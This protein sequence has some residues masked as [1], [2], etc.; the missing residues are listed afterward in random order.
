M[1][2]NNNAFS[3]GPMLEKEKLAANGGKYANW[4]TGSAIWVLSSKLVKRTMFS[5][6]LF[7]KLPQ[8]MRRRTIRTFMQLKWM[9]TP[10][11]SA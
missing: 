4:R 11:C 9:T 1:A 6:Q 8:R 7:Q 10:K 2:R 5:K 3:L